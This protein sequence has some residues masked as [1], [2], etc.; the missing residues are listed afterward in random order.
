M[1]DAE[2]LMMVDEDEVTWPPPPPQQH[3]QQRVDMSRVELHERHGH[4]YL[5]YRP[6]TGASRHRKLQSAGDFDSVYDSVSDSSQEDLRDNVQFTDL[7]LVALYAN[8][9]D[10]FKRSV[11]HIDSSSNIYAK[12]SDKSFTRIMIPARKLCGRAFHGDEVLVEIFEFGKKLDLQQSVVGSVVDKSVVDLDGP[13][14]KVMGVYKRA[15]DPKYRMFVC[16]VEEGNTGVM[17]PLNAGVPKLFNLERHD[18]PTQDGKV[19]IYAFTKAKQ[20]MFDRYQKVHDVSS[21]LFVVRYLKWE[22]HCSLPLGIVISVLPAGVTVES[23]MAILDIEYSIPRRFREATL[24]EVKLQHSAVPRQLPAGVIAQRSD[25]R[26]KLTFTIDPPQSTDLDDALSFEALP[27]GASYVIGVHITDVSYYVSKWSSID[28]EARQRGSSF[29]AATGESTP[30]LP[31]HLSEDLCSLLPD[32]DRLTLSVYIKIN[33]GADILGVEI[34]RSV[35]RSRYRLCYSEVESIINGMSDET[36]YSEELSLAIVSLNRVA[37]LWRNKRLGREALYTAVRYS[38]LDGLKAHVLVEEMMIAAN[39]QVALYLLSRF[40]T[41]TPLRCQSAPDSSELEE[42]KRRFLAA[43]HHSVVLSRPYCGATG[44]DVCYCLGPCQCLPAQSDSDIAAGSNDDRFEM[45]QSL[46]PRIEHAL[47]EFDTDQL[48]SLVVNPEYH[49]RQAVAL[50][51]YRQMQ[52]QSVYRCSGQLDTDMDQRHYALNLCAYVQFTSPLRRYVD[53]VAHRLV[54]NALDGDGPCYSQSDVSDICAQSS[55]VAVRTR[56]YERAG[57][58][59]HFCDLLMKRPLVLLAVVDHVTDT[60]L[61]LVFPTIHSFFPSFTK[62]KL[63]SLNTSSRPVIGSDSE[64]LLVTWSQRIYDCYCNDVMMARQRGLLEINANQYTFSIPSHAWTDL[65]IATVDDDLTRVTAAVEHINSHHVVSP[66]VNEP[67]SEGLDGQ[68]F[69]EYSLRL[70]VGGV[71][72]VQLTTELHRGLLRPCVQLFHVTSST[73]VCVEHTVAAVKCFCKAAT[74]SAARAVYSGSRQ[75]GKLWLPVLAMEAAHGAIAN[76]HS[77]VIHNV[78]IQ[79]SQYHMHGEEPVYLAMF[80]LPVS[81]C[82]NRCIRFAAEQ[83]DE[84]EDELSAA[85]ETADDRC[86]GYMCVRYS[87][88]SVP[89]P[90]VQLPIDKLVN[91]SENVTWVGHCVVSRVLVDEDRLFYSVYLKVHQ[92]CFPLPAQLLDHTSASQQRATVEFI[93]KPLPDRFVNQHVI[94]SNNVYI[95]PPVCLGLVCF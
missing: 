45:M 95:C 88:V 10:V 29:Y 52:C 43:A 3:Q 39:H 24:A 80:K 78:N 14:G 25:C 83:C 42:W 92:S 64:H 94:D 15:V 72:M 6:T 16:Q 70:R 85:A 17:V 20:I 19:T 8:E 49:P 93:D 62:L 86:Q 30:M 48:Q 32:R 71:V 12:P 11:I 51:R 2:R 66:V 68:Q 37:Q 13:W 81:F 56:R 41:Y 23:A 84:D 31:P 27:G 9:P 61:Q 82:K 63:S 65:M 50:V 22:D 28:C 69:A 90:P 74:K 59:A 44:G 79:W 40:P 54:W 58:V 60:H 76:Q 35:V 33:A 75:Y 21:V 87:D 1:E 91:L 53:L 36:E 77:V 26:N 46:W 18:A 47:S 89:V 38:T 34:K 5:R 57:L 73:S 55:D 7:Q 67:S 4:A